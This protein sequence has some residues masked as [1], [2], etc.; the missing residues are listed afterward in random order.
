MDERCNGT[1]GEEKLHQEFTT[2]LS[3]VVYLT[4]LVAYCGS[5][6]VHPSPYFVRVLVMVNSLSENIG[7][8][9]CNLFPE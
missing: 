7:S 1:S 2:S 3:C 6:S 8:L 5:M 9:L 4:A